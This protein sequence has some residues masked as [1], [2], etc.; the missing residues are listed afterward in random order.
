MNDE[1]ATPAER[2][3]PGAR[4]LARR[5][6]LMSEIT[7]PRRRVSRRA[8]WLAGLTGALVISG[9][10]G[11]VAAGQLW[12]GGATDAQGTGCYAEASLDADLTVIDT[13]DRNPVETCADLWRR[14]EVKQ[15]TTKA[16]PLRACL[17]DTGPVG[18]FPGDGGTCER[19]GLRPTRPAS[20]Q[21]SK[22]AIAVRELHD[23]LAKR[24]NA[25]CM[26]KEE[27]TRLVQGRIAAHGLIGW[28]VSVPPDHDRNGRCATFDLDERRKR[29]YLIGEPKVNLVN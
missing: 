11:A 6:H 5:E 21:E 13:T 26:P 17:L 19:L 1:L 10:G 25:R 27:A 29:V 12:D 15:G 9:G 20:P 4:F 3:L 24:L 18:V 7:Q 2:D 16:P 8:R 22:Q 28:T 23:D 14:G